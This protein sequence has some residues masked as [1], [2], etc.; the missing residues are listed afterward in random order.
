MNYPEELTREYDIYEQIGA[1]G[2]V[3]YRAYHRNMRKDV[4]LKRIAAEGI[5]TQD[6]VRK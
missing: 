2:I 4:M 1:G 5:S 6:T 3:V